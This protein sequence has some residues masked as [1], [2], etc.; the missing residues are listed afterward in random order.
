MKYEERNKDE[1]ISSI[2][3]L[4]R[5][6]LNKH[7]NELLGSD[8]ISITTYSYLSEDEGIVYRDILI[9]FDIKKK[10]REVN[11]KKKGGGFYV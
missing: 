10:T 3:Q 8:S 7:A 4:I 2:I 9:R 6:Y 5:T 11:R 1:L